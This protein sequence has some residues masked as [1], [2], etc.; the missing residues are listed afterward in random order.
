M[1][2]KYNRNT[3]MVHPNTVNYPDE[4]MPSNFSDETNQSYVEHFNR[5]QTQIKHKIK[6]HLKLSEKVLEDVNFLD[7]EKIVKGTQSMHSEIVDEESGLLYGLGYDN[8]IHKINKEKQEILSKDNKIDLLVNKLGY[9]DL[10]E[11]LALNRYLLEAKT[12]SDVLVQ[13]KAKFLEEALNKVNKKKRDEARNKFSSI[14]NKEITSEEK[15]N[16]KVEFMLDN[17]AEVKNLFYEN[18]YKIKEMSFREV[19]K[20]LNDFEKYEMLK[21]AA[22]SD[23]NPLAYQMNDDFININSTIGS[24]PANNQNKNNVFDQDAYVDEIIRKYR[25]SRTISVKINSAEIKKKIE[26]FLKKKDFND[27]TFNIY[28]KNIFSMI[29]FYTFFNKYKKMYIPTNM[30]TER[31]IVGN[32]FTF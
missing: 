13:T 12:H 27:N 15:T 1:N 32:I 24:N 18:Y 25:D 20:S 7:T 31:L 9:L 30:E 8:F 21:E 26:S 28:L 16:E 22:K 11:F 23:S 6:D 19:E 10:R 14:E 5:L 4:N 29:K 2:M 3:Q 17:F